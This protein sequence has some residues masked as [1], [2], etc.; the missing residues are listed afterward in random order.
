MDNRVF[1]VTSQGSLRHVLAIA[2]QNAPGRKATHFLVT[3][4]TKKTTYY[5]DKAGQPH[6]HITEW[7]EG[8]GGKPTV[9]L[10]WH[11]EHGA[12][13]LPFPLDE[14]AAEQWLA[15]WLKHAEYGSEPDHDGDNDRGWRAFCTS[16]GHVGSRHYA[17]LAVQPEWAMYGK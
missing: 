8:A 7:V 6:R 17:F 9:V 12:T 2:F 3:H 5:C 1:D 11:E 4:M 14:E 16:W 13:P 10:C 15:Q